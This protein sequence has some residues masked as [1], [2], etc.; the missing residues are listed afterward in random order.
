[1]DRIGG[2]QGLAVLAIGA[3]VTLGAGGAWWVSAAPESPPAPLQT[4][5][6][7]VAEVMA[8]TSPGAYLPAL[9]NTV[10][11]RLGR[12]DPDETYELNIPSE[13]NGLYRL[14]HICFDPG[15]LWARIKGT[16]D[17]AAHHRMSCEGNLETIDFAAAGTQLVVEVHRPGPEPAEVGVQVIALQ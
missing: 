1:V 10:A 4:A 9:D 16:A 2:R 11:R 6:E 17:G 3:V 14:Q 5:P 15:P 12:L 8:K 13:R 7:P